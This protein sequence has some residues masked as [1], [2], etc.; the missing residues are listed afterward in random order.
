MRG[1]RT[2]RAIEAQSKRNP[3]FA[4][5]IKELLC[6]FSENFGV[7]VISSNC[8]LYRPQLLQSKMIAWL[9][10]PQPIQLTEMRFWISYCWMPTPKIA[11]LW[12]IQSTISKWLL[13]KA[14]WPR[15]IRQT[16]KLDTQASSSK[17]VAD[18]TESFQWFFKEILLSFQICTQV[19]FLVV[20]VGLLISLFSASNGSI[21]RLVE[22]TQFNSCG[23]NLTPKFSLFRYQVEYNWVH[24]SRSTPKT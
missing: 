15:I 21:I 10:L 19:A 14:I 8:A 5:R 23:I 4:A 3:S 22:V 9:W 11:I 20:G 17:W 12:T 7:K 6:K 18:F 2:Q 1:F 24:R 13:P 16:E